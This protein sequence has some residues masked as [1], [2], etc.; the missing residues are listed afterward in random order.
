MNS[1][2]PPTTMPR[3]KIFL[4]MVVGGGPSEFILWRD[5]DRFEPAPLTSDIGP[6]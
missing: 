3:K 6:F 4:G 5:P 1:E 2:G